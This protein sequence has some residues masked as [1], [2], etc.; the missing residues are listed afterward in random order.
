MVSLNFN[1]NDVEPTAEFE[2]IPE[3]P[4]DTDHGVRQPAP[5]QALDG[6]VE[7]RRREHAVPDQPLHDPLAEEGASA[8]RGILPQARGG[9]GTGHR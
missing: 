9:Y 4:G 5:L 3:V 8:E 6:P 7:E 1:A 2:P